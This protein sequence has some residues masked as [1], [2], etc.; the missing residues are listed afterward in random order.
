MVQK[1][2]STSNLNT[3]QAFFKKNTPNRN[4]S[5]MYA[6]AFPRFMKAKM[7]HGIEI[8]TLKLVYIRNFTL[9]HIGSP[10]M[11]GICIFKVVS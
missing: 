4:E 11:R 8:F 10:K 7:H 3:V 9:F 2:I 6:V 5:E 1:V